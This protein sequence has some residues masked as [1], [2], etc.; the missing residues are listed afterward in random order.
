MLHALS[1][2]DVLTGD[3]TDGRLSI[4]NN[5]SERLLRGIAVSQRTSC[6]SVPTGAAS[7]PRSF[8]R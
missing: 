6:S 1:H 5:L 2:W 7:A 4:D 8:I 3:T